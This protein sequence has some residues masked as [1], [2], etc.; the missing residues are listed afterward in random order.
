MV[1]VW[2]LSSGGLLQE[3]GPFETPVTYLE[4]VASSTACNVEPTCTST[5]KVLDLLSWG[6]WMG[7][8]GSSLGPM[9]VTPFGALRFESQ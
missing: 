2:S 9:L 1:K 6:V 5:E 4:W 7:A 3:M 8:Q